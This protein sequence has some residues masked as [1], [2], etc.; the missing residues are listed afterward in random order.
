MTCTCSF[1]W[2]LTAS[3]LKARKRTESAM[4]NQQWVLEASKDFDVN[5]DMHFSCAKPGAA[6][7]EQA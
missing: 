6:S 4:P 7:A 5:S 3:C 2:P 1:D